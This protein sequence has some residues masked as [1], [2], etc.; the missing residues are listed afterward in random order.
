MSKQLYH[1]L[2]HA[3]DEEGLFYQNYYPYGKSLNDAINKISYF[4]AKVDYTQVEVV[5]HTLFSIDNLPS[6]VIQEDDFD[7]FIHNVKYGY[8]EDEGET[9]IIKNI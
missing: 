3:I 5:E 1:L 6:D 7:G 8:D 9:Y 4:L 2:I